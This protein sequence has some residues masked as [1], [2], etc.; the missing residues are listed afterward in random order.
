MIA[1][2]RMS[3]PRML[4]LSYASS[5]SLLELCWQVQRRYYVLRE[6]RWA[7]SL[8]PGLLGVHCDGIPA[9]KGPSTP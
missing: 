3:P 7:S 4:P 2:P 1:H 9:L 6:G 8:C 5:V